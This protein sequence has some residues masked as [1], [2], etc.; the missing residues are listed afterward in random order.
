MSRAG[1]EAAIANAQA[2]GVGGSGME[3]AMREMANQQGAERASN[4][5]L[6]Q[7]AA[8]A[9]QRALYNQMYQQGLGQMRQQDAQAGQYNNDVINKFNAMNTQNRNQMNQ[10]NVDMRNQAQKMNNQG[11]IDMQQQNYDN[12]L[13]RAGGM[14]GQYGNMANAEAAAG[15]ARANERNQLIGVGAG[16]AG[17]YLG[18]K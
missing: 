12:Q 13:K 5:G 8:A 16:L 4:A 17:S 15:A 11:R 6:E 9:R 18:R 2:R 10:A 14:A 1:T 3:F 7:A